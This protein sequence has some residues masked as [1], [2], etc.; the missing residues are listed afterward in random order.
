[1]GVQPAL[2]F[3]FM[4]H[5]FG[6]CFVTSPG[7]S[8]IVEEATLRLVNHDPTSTISVECVFQKTRAL[9]VDCPPTVLEPG[10]SLDV[11]ICF[12]PRDVKD[13]AFVVPFVINGTSKVNL[14]IMG[15]G[16]QAR[17]EMANASQRRL[18]FG[19]VNVGADVRKSVA[20]VNRSKR[21]LPVQIIDEGGHYG[22]GRLGE[23]CVTFF[24]QHEVIVAPREVLNVQIVFQPNKR[25]SNFS[26]DLMIRYAGVTRSLLTV[27]GKAQGSEVSLDMDSIPFGPV[28]EGSQK[29]RRLV[30][31]NSG[32]VPISFNW[33]EATFGPHITI[34]PLSGKLAPGNDVAFE[35]VFKPR[36]LDEDI[37]QDNILLN[38]PGM[39][40][41]TLTCSGACV[42]QPSG[43]IQLMQFNSLARKE[44]I[45][46]VKL[47]NPTD[48]EW[49]LSPSLRARI[50]RC[51]RKLRCLPRELTTCQLRTSH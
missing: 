15:T 2:R 19:L 7:G 4:Q 11:P 26:E 43:S 20:L 21:A 32:D 22:T 37:R 46:Y 5:D 27:S 6:P 1:M 36:I 3:S 14:N 47:Q 51:L 30:L 9:W 48:K 8:T 41:L 17:L 28:V 34:T 23:R 35:V 39:S 31:E 12:A 45:K 16:I 29:V 18:N 50:G 33:M 24:P 44:E 40:P 38:V 13:Y 42:P 10:C 25:V 49:Y